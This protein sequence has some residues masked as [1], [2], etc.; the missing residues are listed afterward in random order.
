M[1]PIIVHI[2]YVEVKYTPYG[3]KSVDDICKMAAEI[4]Y[5][6]IEFRSAPPFELKELPMKES[7]TR[8]AEEEKTVFLT[9]GLYGRR[10]GSPAF[11][12]ASKVS[13]IQLPCRLRGTQAGVQDK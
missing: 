6:G 7:F 12:K 2:N 9:F 1:N 5:D 4:G 10:Q 11:C 8:I 3:T 13:I